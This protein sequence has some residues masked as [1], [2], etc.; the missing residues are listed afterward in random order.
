MFQITFSDL[1]SAA[2]AAMP[3]TQQLDLLSEFNVSPE[4]LTEGSSKFGQISR[5]GRTLYRYRTGDYRLYF[6]KVNNGILVRCVLHKNTLKDFVFRSKLPVSEDEL[7][8]E[9][10]KFWDLI[11]HGG[12]GRKK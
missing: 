11:D 9:N 4:D 2:L 5:K 10:P 6:E 7:L 12:I 8:A 1:S 3:K